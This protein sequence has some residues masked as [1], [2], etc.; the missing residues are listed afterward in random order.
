MNASNR[1][2][3]LTEDPKEAIKAYRASSSI[4]SRVFKEVCFGHNWEWREKCFEIVKNHKDIFLHHH[5][6]VGIL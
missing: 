6:E 3:E 5:I 2:V 4:D 1:M